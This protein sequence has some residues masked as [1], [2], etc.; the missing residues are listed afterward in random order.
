[1]PTG[2]DGHS[3]EII[4]RLTFREQLILLSV[5]LFDSHCFSLPVHLL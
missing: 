1:M 2:A 3:L 5:E 4:S